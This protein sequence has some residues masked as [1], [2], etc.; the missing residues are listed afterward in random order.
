[1][2][3]APSS[4]K[5]DDIGQLVEPFQRATEKPRPPRLGTESEKF[6]VLEGSGKPMSYDGRECG[7]LGVF[8]ALC[9]QQQWTPVREREDGPII[10]LE[11]V[12]EHGT[13]SI[14][15][16]PGAQLELSGA[17]VKTVHDIAQEL[18]EHL[19]DLGPVSKSCGVRWLATGYHP[20]ATPEQLPWVPKERYAVMRDYFPK[21]GKR[22]LDMMRR[23]A[24]VQVNFD[25]NDERDA[26]RKMRVALKLSPVATAIFANSPFAEGRITGSRSERALVWLDTDGDRAGLLPKLLEPGAGYADYAAWALDVPMYLFKRDGKV[27]ANTGQTFRSFMQDGYEGHHATMGDWVHH[28]NTLFPEVRLQRTIEVRGV[29]SLPRRWFCALPA[30]W[31]GIL[32]DD[33]ALEAA[34]ALVAELD[35]EILRAA[36]PAVAASALGAELG[37]KPMRAWAESAIGIALDGLGRRA[38]LDAS[39]QDER[40]HLQAIA[41][42]AASGRCPADVLLEGLDPNA[43]DLRAQITARCGVNT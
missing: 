18:E 6:G 31:A 41:E 38:H 33:Q 11:R 2:A 17:P 12:N 16:E 39:G 28:L 29:D 13:L 19:A 15:L 9:E 40:I 3:S 37:G 43:P 20:L 10:A 36:R 14:T 35:F 34:D 24:T 25:Y 5:L 30:F 1:M 26:M 7:V 22:G 21:V 23:T 4:A 8:D 32:Y 42:L 27:I